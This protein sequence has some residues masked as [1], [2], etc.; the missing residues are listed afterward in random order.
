MITV[1]KTEIVKPLNSEEYG[2]FSWT[3]TDEDIKSQKLYLDKELIGQ[4]LPT[5][6]EY[7]FFVHTD[8]IKTYVYKLVINDTIEKEIEVIIG[9]ITPPSQEQEQKEGIT[10]YTCV[11][12]QFNPELATKKVIKNNRSDITLTPT[13]SQK[14]YI[15][16]PKSEKIS[17]Y[18]NGGLYNFD[19]TPS[20][21]T[22]Q[23]KIYIVQ[24]G[25]YKITEPTTLTI[26]IK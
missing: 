14:Y 26:V 12:N 1:N 24:E 23:G 13:G 15:A 8:C 4:L 10:I 16:Y 7:N 6:R 2:T 9:G 19:K 25:D 3:T 20:E 17:I 5:T 11:G 22:I 18:E 21:L